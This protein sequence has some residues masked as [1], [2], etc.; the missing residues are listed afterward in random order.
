MEYEKKQVV[1]LN[2]IE[3]FAYHGY[4]PQEQLIGTTFIVD[5]CVEFEPSVNT[6][7]EL[8]ETIDYVKVNDIVVAE[9]KQTSQLLETVAERII[10]QLISLNN[11]I[12][13]IRV[14]IKKMYP[15]MAT[16][17]NNSN[18][19]LEYQRKHNAV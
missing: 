17:V 14:S 12:E 19:I 5:V 2:G 15:P 16:V 11:T 8:S 1:A 4:Y 6:S 9:M 7:D 3:V 13:L 18:I 10:N